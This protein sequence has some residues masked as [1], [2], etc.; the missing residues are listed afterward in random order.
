MA[1]VYWLYFFLSESKKKIPK[2]YPLTKEDLYFTTLKKTSKFN[3]ALN[4]VFKIIIIINIP[5]EML[6]IK[7]G[8]A[9]S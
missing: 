8:V 2:P 1:A 5:C 3:Y 4:Y 9:L 6:V 7:P